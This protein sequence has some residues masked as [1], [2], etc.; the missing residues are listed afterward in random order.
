MF[1]FLVWILDKSLNSCWP[2]PCHLKMCNTRKFWLYPRWSAPQVTQ[3]YSICVNKIL[4][5]QE[6]S[7]Y[8]TLIVMS[9]IINLKNRNSLKREIVFWNIEII[10]LLSFQQFH[11]SIWMQW[12]ALS[13]QGTTRATLK[14]FLTVLYCVSWLSDC[15]GHWSDQGSSEPFVEWFISEEITILIVNILITP[16]W[17]SRP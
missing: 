9:S 3:Q 6:F 7:H 10:S 4:I 14:A 2:A 16:A 12:K 15:H 8:D 13:K 17:P 11:S 5:G 1:L